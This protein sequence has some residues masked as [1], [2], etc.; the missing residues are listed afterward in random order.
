M[1]VDLSVLESKESS[2]ERK[3]REKRE[4]KENGREK[5]HH[6]VGQDAAADAMKNFHNQ[7]H[8]RHD[9]DDKKKG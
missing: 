3:K 8:H 7:V 6:H 5:K 2:K 1:S 4:K 9:A